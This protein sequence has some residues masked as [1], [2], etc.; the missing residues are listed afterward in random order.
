MEELL[1]KYYWTDW[2]H[3]GTRHPV[4]VITPHKKAILDAVKIK[5][6]TESRIGL[7]EW[8]GLRNDTLDAFRCRGKN[9]LHKLRSFGN[10]WH[11]LPNP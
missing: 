11:V 10:L 9:N 6:G 7:W 3:Q 5:A 1:K 2:K 4:D 8:R